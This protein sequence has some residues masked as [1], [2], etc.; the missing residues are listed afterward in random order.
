MKKII[1]VAI[2]LLVSVSLAG[3]GYRMGWFAKLPI[4]ALAS[5]VPSSSASGPGATAPAASPGQAAQLPGEAAASSAPAQAAA[6]AGTPTEPPTQTP[7]ASATDAVGG[8]LIPAPAFE[9]N[10]A[11]LDFGGT[12]EAWTTDT[13]ESADHQEIID[14][15]PQSWVQWAR[16]KPHPGEFVLSFF[17]REPMLIDRVVLRSGT[18]GNDGVLALFPKDVEI[19]DLD[20][21][22]GGRPLRE[23]RG[24]HAP[25]G[26]EP[27]R[28]KGPSP[29]PRWKPDS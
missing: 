12:V 15:G 23:G 27:E 29:S 13:N 10:V 7:P 5:L 17:A 4:P 21:R 19:L 6:P 18:G 24:R 20:G 9:G 26:E 25:A 11:S 3:L 28:T 16:N 2:V 1:A 8:R 14:G 22:D